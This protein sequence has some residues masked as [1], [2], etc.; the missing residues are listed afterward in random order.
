MSYDPRTIAFL[1]ELLYPPLQLRSD[2]AQ[3]LHNALYKRNE[4]RYLNFQ[5]AQDGIHM[6]NVPESPGS[7]SQLTL[8]PDRLVMREEL[9][10]ITHEDFAQRLVQVAGIVLPHLGVAQSLAQQFIVRSLINPR[11]SQD[12]REFLAHRL[13]GADDPPWARFGRPIASLGLRLTFPQTDKHRDMYH[14]RVET[15][16]Q[17]PR[18][19]WVELAGSFTNPVSTENLPEIGSYVHATY[20]FL[21]GPAFEF[22][23]G[24]DQPK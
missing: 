11:H 19:L 4:T 3:A 12:S 18:S 17:D 24:F 1:A 8:L 20:R 21:C 16:T 9:R 13:I 15:W 14:L 7:V 6:L 22:L 5:I 2:T 10:G 23:A